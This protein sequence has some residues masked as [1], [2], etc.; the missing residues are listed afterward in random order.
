MFEMM[1][2]AASPTVSFNA[3]SDH[4]A[5]R[6]TVHFSV[7]C[8][9][10]LE[11]VALRHQIGILQRAVKRP[12]LTPTD[13]LLWVVLSRV[14]SDWRSALAVHRKGFR[15][16]WTWKV[17]RGQPGRPAISREVRDLIRG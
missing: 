13:R 12:K 1:E 17:R 5:R 16:F 10:E 7:P 4:I 14:W 8:G 2:V 3:H 11:I 6:P 9:P 15:L